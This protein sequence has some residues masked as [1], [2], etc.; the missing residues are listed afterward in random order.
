MK[1]RTMLATGA[2]ALSLSA[3]ALANQVAGKVESDW[4][5]VAFTGQPPAGQ[6]ATVQGLNNYKRLGDCTRA[7]NADL[8][9]NPERWEYC[10][11]FNHTNSNPADSSVGGMAVVAPNY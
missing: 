8:S 2:I 11:K 4:V 1:L 7:I 10:A 5:I 6:P 3:P 9:V